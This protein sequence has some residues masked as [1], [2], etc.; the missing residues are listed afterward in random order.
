MDEHGFDIIDVHHHYETGYGVGDA[1]ALARA[2][3]KPGGADLELETR[4]TGMNAEHVRGA[5]I[6]AGSTYL[7]PNGIADTAAVNDAVAAYRNREPSRFVAAVGVMEPLYGEAGFGEAKRCKEQLGLVGISFHNQF[8]GTPINSPLM[9]SLIEKI[10]EADLIPFIHA[11]GSMMETLYQ[12][13]LLA[14]HFPDLKMAVLDVFH[15]I[16]QLKSL[17]DIAE[18]R[19]NLYFDLCLLVSFETLA[20]PLVRAVGAD[21]FLYGTN[22]Y[23]WPLARKP[24]GTLLPAILGS[25]LSEEDKTK[26]LSGNIQAIL[27]PL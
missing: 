1:L 14:K 26:I 27:G 25:D 3:G 24:Q 15:D 5:I 20:L 9:L 16:N 13:D 10:A 8:Q 21:R 12:V 6:I 4:L 11:Y 22:Q 17:P 7:R 2:E 23:S 19:P 18:R